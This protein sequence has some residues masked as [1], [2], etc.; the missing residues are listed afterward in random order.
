[1]D[2]Q[3]PFSLTQTNPTDYSDAAITRLFN[4]VNKYHDLLYTL[5]LNEVTGNFQDNNNGKGG[6]GNDSVIVDAQNGYSTYT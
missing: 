6:L 4:T 1:M 5:G 3:Y 2:F